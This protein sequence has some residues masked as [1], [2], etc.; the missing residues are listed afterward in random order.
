MSQNDQAV[1][2][3]AVGYVFTAAPG[4]PRPT[5]AQIASIDPEAFGSSSST[6]TSSEAPTGGTFSL[7]VGE[8][9]VAPKQAVETIP[10]KVPAEGASTLEATGVEPPTVT[11]DAKTVSSK[12]AKTSKAVAAE[13]PVAKDA[14]SGTT[15]ELPFD[16][17]AAEV[18]TALENIEGVGAGNVKVT[19]GGFADDGFVIAFVGKLAG[20]NIEVTVNSKL[21]PATVTA[22]AEVATA[23]NG[24][25][26]LGHTSRD[27]LP[28]FGFDGGDTEVRGTWQNENLREVVTQ[29]IADYLT[30]L[31]QQFD[32]QSFE[33][34]YGKDSAKAAGVF[35]VASG[36]ATP[37]EKALLIIIVDGETKIGFY[38]PKA[39]M[40]RD[41]SISLATDEFA[42]LPVRATFLKY[43]S[44][45]K[46][47]WINEDLFS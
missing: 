12:T 44:A 25:S 17:G 40:R 16:S 32:T 21:E 14:P 23:P 47:E 41:D 19:G 9:T 22:T 13:E 30:I 20:E 6:V 28:E 18:Q 38:S 31:L 10:A 8:G 27:D 34:Y 42:S 15:L 7:T 35:G 24:W 45:N 29:P 36:T 1:V 5:P 2:T 4:T 46:F 11:P 33:L 43:G 26:T 39:S 37:V 3:A